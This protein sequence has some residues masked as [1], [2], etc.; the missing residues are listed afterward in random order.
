MS[1]RHTVL[2]LLHAEEVIDVGDRLSHQEPSVAET[3]PALTAG[4]GHE[5][6]D[7]IREQG[8][9]VHFN[10]GAGDHLIAAARHQHVN[11]GSGQRGQALK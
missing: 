5:Q 4:E 8:E 9:A 6:G 1:E 10:I 2:E 11:I 3:A 7:V